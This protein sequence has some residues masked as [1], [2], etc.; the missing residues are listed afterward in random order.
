MKKACITGITG[1]TG[2]YLA[3]ILLE[4]GYEVHG[5][6]RRSSSFNTGRID[7]IYNDLHLT[8]GDLSDYG[9][10][11]NWVI[12]TTPDIFVNCGAQSH[13]RVSFDIPEYT[14][15]I[16]ATGVIRCLEALANFSPGT[17]FVQ[18]STSELWGSSPPPQN[19]NTPFHPR[20]PYAVAKIAGYWATV[21]YRESGKLFAANSIS[22]N[23][24][25]IGEKTPII[26]RRNNVVDVCSAQ[27]LIPLNRKGKSIQTFDILGT[28]I[29]DGQKWVQ[30]KTITATYRR[31]TNPDH[32]MLFVEARGG[33][34]NC[35]AHHTMILDNETELRA[36]QMKAGDLA[37]MGELPDDLPQFV[38]LTKELAELLGLLVA[39][40]SVCKNHIRF[41]NQDK[42]LLNKVKELWRV[43][44][45]GK[46]S[47]AE[48]PSGFEN[49]KPVTQLELIGCPSIGAWV[50]EQIYDKK[51]KL[52]KVPA[53]IL[54]SAPEIK[55][56]FIE[57]YYAGDGLKATTAIS[58]KTNSPIL[59]Q[60]LCLLYFS[61]GLKSSVYVEHRMDRNYYQLNVLK[62][63]TNCARTKDP[64]EIRKVVEDVAPDDWVFDIETSSGVFCAGVGRVIVHN[65]PRRG[66]T[67]VTRKII[68]AA[69]RIKLGLQD[70]LILGNL[71]AKRDWNHAKD[72]ANAIY[73][74]AT[75]P[76]PDDWVVASGEMHSVRDFLELVFTK[77]DLDWTKYVEFDPKYLR[78]T[79]VDALCGDSTK[80]RTQLGW[81]PEYTFDQLVDEMIEH[82]LE[83][84]NREKNV[85]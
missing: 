76:A 85:G 45:L 22:L 51:T 84:A 69:T 32:K 27:S 46:T 43:V 4:K 42:T 30:L 80:I 82:D 75:A 38:A 60:G 77:L 29:W 57:G 64:A 9:S 31:Q 53:I 28:E 73:L 67:F 7:H 35:T 2:S 10:I 71:D 8:Y 11:T 36:D 70:K 56:A 39:E 34:V 26:I 18:C 44:F 1:Q 79:E 21:N 54:N 66:E 20:S 62:N 49:G 41:T 72:V 52:K 16:G 55:Q 61:F 63:S 15:D 25:C 81:A 48:Y 24:E 14:V 50:S 6:L 74:M 13:V 19:E 40:G 12:K 59:A 23:H 65:S 47:E 5:L 3:E 17:H 78:P 68:R 37:L 83:L 58:I 33:I